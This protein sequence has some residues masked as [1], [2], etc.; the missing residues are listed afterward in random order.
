MNLQVA[1]QSPGHC[2]LKNHFRRED[3][4]KT[5]KMQFYHTEKDKKILGKKTII[6][7]DLM[8][9]ETML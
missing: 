4:H 6:K 7:D 8:S 1:Y 5:E 2:Y 3:Y 9:Y